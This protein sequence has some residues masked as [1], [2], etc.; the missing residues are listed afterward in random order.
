MHYILGNKKYILWMEI[1]HLIVNISWRSVVHPRCAVSDS[2]IPFFRL[3]YSTIFF[4]SSLL[5]FFFSVLLGNFSPLC[6][7]TCL[8]TPW[9]KGSPSGRCKT[10]E[11]LMRHHILFIYASNILLS[12]MYPGVIVFQDSSDSHP[13]D[14]LGVNHT[15]TCIPAATHESAFF[16]R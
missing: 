7:I 13:D 12:L 15:P 10:T 5:I 8:L 3:P 2:L 4:F 16:I 11:L 6:C 9:M 1:K 14:S